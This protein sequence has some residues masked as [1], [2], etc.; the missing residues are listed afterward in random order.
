MLAPMHLLS[1]LIVSI[2]AFAGEITITDLKENN[3]IGYLGVP[4]GTTVVVEGT[5]EALGKQSAEIRIT[6]VNDK[7]LKGWVLLS[8]NPKMVD[9]GK[10]IQGQT[11]ILLGFESVLMGVGIWEYQ[12]NKDVSSIIDKFEVVDGSKPHEKLEMTNPKATPF[13]N[14]RAVLKRRN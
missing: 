13:F 14:V 2:C 7:L 4:I 5:V 11:A 8:F 1:L 6:S 10:I 3:V 9:A 12:N